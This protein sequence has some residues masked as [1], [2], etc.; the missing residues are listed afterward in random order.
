MKKILLILTLLLL[1]PTV[2]AD[3]M[4]V[5]KPYDTWHFHDE[6]QQLAAIDYKNGYQDMILSI[7][8]NEIKGEKAVWLFPVPAQPER[9][10]ID[11][12]DEIPRYYGYDI[13]SLADRRIREALMIMRLSQ[14]YTFPLL[15]VRYYGRVHEDASVATLAKQAGVIVHERVEKYGLTTELISTKDGTVLWNYLT[16]KGLE[17]PETSRSVM[18][19]YIGEDY[20]FV[21]SWI[22]NSSEYKNGEYEGYQVGVSGKTAEPIKYYPNKRTIGVKI[23]F[24]TDKIYFPLKPTSVYE[25][26]RVPALIY[27]AGH[28][29]PELYPEIELD[30][31][32]RYFS[33]YT[34][35]FFNKAYST[36]NDYTLIRINPPSKYLTQDLWIEDKVP[37]E[38]KTTK[39]FAKYPLA[40]GILAFVL[41]SMLASLSAGLIFF[42]KDVSIIKLAFFGLW[43]FLTIIGVIIAVFFLKTKK[44]DE[45]LEQQIKEKGLVIRARDIRKLGFVILF[46]IFFVVL[47]FIL[48]YS[49]KLLV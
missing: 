7:D 23:T 46:S 49:L 17:L 26:K 12:V 13:K 48:E 39:F 37:T 41:A 9:T 40:Y 43:N 33:S 28:V 45:K 38:V 3:G 32:V 20:S 21:V 1:L 10:V 4:V 22:S 2:L 27:V 42:R 29:T 8:I 44:I 24:P 34:Y 36:G 47:T 25:S 19:E 35:G 16:L 6:Q 31:E 18:N 11:V 14:I 30:S 5:V 15:G